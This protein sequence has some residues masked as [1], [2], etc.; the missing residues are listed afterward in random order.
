F[1][2][3]VLLNARHAAPKTAWFAFILMAVGGLMANFVVL[4]DPK[5][6]VAYTAYVPLKASPL[7]Y[8]SYI[9]FAVGALIAVVTFFINIVVAKR[10]G[11]FEGSLPLVV[12]GFMT[13]AIIA[14]YTLLEGAAA[15]VP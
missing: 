14:T 12:F 11:R 3:T 13:A 1:G 9:L 8:L 5:N 7:F 2:S 4:L 6:T 10:E 15:V